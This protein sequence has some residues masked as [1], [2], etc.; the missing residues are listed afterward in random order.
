MSKR[1]KTALLICMLFCLTLFGAV[2]AACSPTEDDPDPENPGT[3]EPGENP[4]ENPG[5]EPE[6]PV[7][8][9]GRY[10]VTVVDENGDPVPNLTI[11]MCNSSDGVCYIPV[12]TNTNGVAAFELDP[13]DYYF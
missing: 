4:G 9:E 8:E 7:P 11:N 10:V 3:E 5:E 12:M 1:L 2:F 6:D 13:G